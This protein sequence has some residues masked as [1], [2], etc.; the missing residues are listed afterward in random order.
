MTDAQRK[1]AFEGPDL[2]Q[3]AT[4]LLNSFPDKFRQLETLRQAWVAA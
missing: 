3:Q 1:W 4:S 2:M